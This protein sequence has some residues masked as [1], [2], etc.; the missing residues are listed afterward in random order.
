MMCGC[1]LGLNLDGYQGDSYLPII[2]L[3]VILYHKLFS[4]PFL[5]DTPKLNM[6]AQMY[7][8]SIKTLL[9]L[10]KAGF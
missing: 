4:M 8:G 6:T 3:H 2:L 10:D 9:C 1:V 7:L 5:H